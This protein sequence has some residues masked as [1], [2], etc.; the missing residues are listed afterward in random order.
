[1][2]SGMT[3]RTT[4]ASGR[5]TRETAMV[6]CTTLMGELKEED[7]PITSWSLTAEHQVS[8]TLQKA[9]TPSTLLVSLVLTCPSSPEEE[10]PPTGS[11]MAATTLAAH[12][13][14]TLLQVLSRTARVRRDPPQ[15]DQDQS[16]RATLFSN[17]KISTNSLGTICD[18]KTD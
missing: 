13:A 8:Q 17:Q 2:S 3:G 15:P 7:G 14:R 1:M 6:S 9:W 12:T 4:L 11:N 10:Q 18:S 16:L 5:M